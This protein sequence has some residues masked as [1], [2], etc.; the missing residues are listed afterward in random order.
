LLLF[1]MLSSLR[2]FCIC[3]L[4]LPLFNSAPAAG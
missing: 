2:T 1:V 4:Q 3:F